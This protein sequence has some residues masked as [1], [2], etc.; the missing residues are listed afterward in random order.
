MQHMTYKAKS[1]KYKMGKYTFWCCP[2]EGYPFRRLTELSL[3]PF[4]EHH[5][6]SPWDTQAS[7]AKLGR[8]PFPVLKLY[9]IR[10]DQVGK[11]ELELTSSSKEPS[12]TKSEV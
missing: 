2:C 5:I 3:L 8:G 9:I 11:Q 10:N 4:L 12:W 7:D 1:K 6:G